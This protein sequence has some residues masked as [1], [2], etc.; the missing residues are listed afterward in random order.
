MFTNAGD[1]DLTIAASSP[2]KNQGDT[3]ALPQD[4]ADLDNDGTTNE[5][6]PLDRAANPRVIGA[7]VDMGAFEQP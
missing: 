3:A 2:V 7:A 4:D 1:D 6:T 5:V